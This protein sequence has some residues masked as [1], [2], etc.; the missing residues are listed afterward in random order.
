MPL[1]EIWKAG[2]PCLSVS[3]AF[4][5]S[6][7]RLLH[8]VVLQTETSDTF[9]WQLAVWSWAKISIPMV[10]LTSD[11]VVI[12]ECS[13]THNHFANDGIDFGHT[14]IVISR[15]GSAQKPWPPAWSIRSISGLSP[16]GLTDSLERAP[17]WLRPNPGL[18]VLQ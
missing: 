17:A 11:S 13:L 2:V 16:Q 15:R 10:V 12:I 3:S 6:A 14:V 1:T 5:H 8:L 4:G 7:N 18:H 9:D